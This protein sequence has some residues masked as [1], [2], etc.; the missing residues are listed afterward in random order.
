MPV[1]LRPRLAIYAPNGYGLYDMAGNVWEWCLDEFDAAF[2]SISPRRNPLSGTGTAEW[3][4][5]NFLSLKAHRVL[6]GSPG[7]AEYVRVAHRVKYNAVDTFSLLGFR[8]VR[9]VTKTR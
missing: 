9:S 1:M 3:V 2:Y 5:N 8:C 4:M 6:R 7:F